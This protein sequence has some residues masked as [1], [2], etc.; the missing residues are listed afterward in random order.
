MMLRSLP[1]VSILFFAMGCVTPYEPLPPLGTNVGVGRLDADEEALWKQSRELQYQIEV[2][3]LLFEDPKLDAYLSKLLQRVT[4]PELAE[5]S[6]TPQARVVSNVNI[7]GYSFA[8]GVIYIHTALLS[9]MQNEA[10]LA[11]LLSRELAHIVHRHALR[12]HRDKR[13]RAD[14][15]AWIGVGATLVDGGGEAKLLAQAASITTA[16]GFHHHLETVADEK[17]L[18]ILHDAGYPVQSTLGLYEAS[19]THLAEVHAQGIWGWAPFTPPP[20][21][22]ARISGYETLIARDYARKKPS[23]SPMADTAGFRRRVHTA[24]LR[25]CDLELAV[26]LFISAETCARLA[27]ESRPTDPNGWMLL[28]RALAGQRSRPIEGKRLPSLK[29][30]RNAFEQVLILDVR[31][32]DA[33]RE[34]GMSFYRTTGTQRTPDASAEARRYFRRYLQLAPAAGDGDYV[35]GY[36]R[37]LEAEAR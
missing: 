5:A 19:L 18:A 35:R 7:H 29:A 16:A 31:H 27:T 34:L 21:I 9:R 17:G 2:S 25:Q 32:A 4:P 36:L 33:T 30:V 24:T 23:R 26:G 22:S 3:G 13:L 1:F 10:Q 8:N 11:A 14:T 37:E 28:G 12:G 6:L 15:L 20:Q